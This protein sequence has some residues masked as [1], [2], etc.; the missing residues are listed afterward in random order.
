MV[1]TWVLSAPDGPHVGPMNLAIWVRDTPSIMY[2][3]HRDTVHAY[4][5]TMIL[6]GCL[7][8]VC[9]LIRNAWLKT[10]S[11]QFWKNYL[12]A[13]N[14]ALWEA[15]AW[16]INGTRM[17][18]LARRLCWWTGTGCQADLDGC[19]TFP[20]LTQ[21]NPCCPWRWWCSSRR[22]REYKAALAT[23]LISR[24]QTAIIGHDFRIENSTTH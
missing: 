5:M 14:A 16:W 2:E 6:D 10:T 18:R 8:W 12:M 7:L 1:P 11:K 20:A 3:M 24:M 15:V 22:W 4:K 13:T 19:W 9:N 21:R 17:A 23:S